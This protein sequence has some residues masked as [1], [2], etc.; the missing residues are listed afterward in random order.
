MSAAAVAELIRLTL[1]ID[2]ECGNAK[3]DFAKV[4]TLA[5]EAAALARMEPQS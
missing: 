3:P 1:A 4:C 2:S 5:S